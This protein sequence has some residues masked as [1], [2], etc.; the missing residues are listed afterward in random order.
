MK[1]YLVLKN[2][3]SRNATREYIA[4]T[5][6]CLAW[7]SRTKALEEMGYIQQNK[8]DV[9]VTSIATALEKIFGLGRE[10]EAKIQKLS[11]SQ[12]LLEVSEE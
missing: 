8:P 1:S 5:T 6:A 10:A 9:L 3:P 4:G 7:N 12:F 2:F 11:D